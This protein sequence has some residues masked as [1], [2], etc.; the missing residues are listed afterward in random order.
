MNIYEAE[1][2]DLN[3][4]WSTPL[5]RF[6]PFVTLAF[7]LLCVAL[8]APCIPWAFTSNWWTQPAIWEI[9]FCVFFIIF[10]CWM[11]LLGISLV[12]QAMRNLFNVM[13]GF[14]RINMM[15][16]HLLI[17]K[18]ELLWSEID[19]LMFEEFS[20]SSGPSYRYLAFINHQGSRFTFDPTRSSSM[21][22]FWLHRKV[23]SKTSKY[24]KETITL[25]PVDFF[26]ASPHEIKVLAKRYWSNAK[27][28]NYVPE[29]LELMYPQKKFSDFK[30]ITI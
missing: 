17:G 21:V 28:Q 14:G 2:F 5:S 18:F 27:G 3:L 1:I 9:V 7:G 19:D 6:K 10:G 24:Q 25:V 4:S 11:A 22:L 26:K 13:L 8:G 20:H 23:F 12:I 30:K 15:P 16:T 29:S